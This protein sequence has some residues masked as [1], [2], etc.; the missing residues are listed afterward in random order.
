MADA[1]LQAV[2]WRFP[3]AEDVIRALHRDD[4]DFRSICEELAI[5]ATA[6][7]RW[8]DMPER[9]IEYGQ[10]LERLQDELLDRLNKKQRGASLEP[11]KQ[12]MKDDDRNT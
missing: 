2:I 7:E 8:K 11:F 9:A 3:Q 4:P 6:R 1:Y 5:A 12:G 10:I